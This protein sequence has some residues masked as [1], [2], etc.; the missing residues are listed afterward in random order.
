VSGLA[1]AGIGPLLGTPA[2][3]CGDVVNVPGC[4]RGRGQAASPRA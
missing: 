1:L 3:R 2:A 4:K